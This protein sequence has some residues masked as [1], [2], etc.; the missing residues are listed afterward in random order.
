[1]R[2]CAKD[3]LRKDLQACFTAYPLPE[4]LVRVTQALVDAGGLAGVSPVTA[5]IIRDLQ[6]TY[7]IGVHC[8]GYVRACQIELHGAQF[9]VYP[10]PPTPPPG[11]PPVTVTFS[12]ILQN[13]RLYDQQPGGLAAVARARPGDVLHLAA[14]PRTDNREHN[15]VIRQH[16]ILTTADPRWGSLASAPSL[17]SSRGPVHLLDIVQSAGG[18]NDIRGVR[19]ETWLF[20]EASGAWAIHDPATKTIAFYAEGPGGHA[21]GALYAPKRAVR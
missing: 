12:Y 1:M 19:H 13:N 4:Q 3:P 16:D 2:A 20:D 7:C 14:S 15:V 18:K 17:L 21:R 6:A 9:D 8:M 10:N 5:Q 11:K